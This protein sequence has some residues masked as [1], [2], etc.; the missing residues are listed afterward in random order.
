MTPPNANTKR[1]ELARILREKARAPVIAPLSSGQYRLWKIATLDPQNPVYNISLAYYL[2][3]QIDTDILHKSFELL[4]KRHASLRTHFAVHDDVPVQMVPPHVDV[5]FREVRLLDVSHDQLQASVDTLLHAEACRPFDLAVGPL[6]RFTLFALRTDTHVLSIT[7]HHMVGDRW[8]FGILIAELGEIYRCLQENR[9]VVL[10]PLSRTYVEFSTDQA[11]LLRSGI[12]QEQITFWDSELGEQPQPLVIPTGDVDPVAARSSGVRREFTIDAELTQQLNRFCAAQNVTLFSVVLASLSI[13]LHA[14]TGQQEM[15]VC[16]PLV[17]RYRAKTKDI[18]G[19][20]NNILPLRFYCS[21]SSTLEEHIA[22]L[23]EVARR[24][25]SNQDLPFEAI[26]NLDALR[27]VPL[28]RCMV[29]VQDVDGLQLILPN[30]TTEYRDIYSGASDFDISLFVESKTPLLSVLF[31]FRPSIVGPNIADQLVAHFQKILYQVASAPRQTIEQTMPSDVLHRTNSQFDTETTLLAPG[32]NPTTGRVELECRLLA[33][34]EDI[35]GVAPLDITDNFFRL[36]GHSFLAARLF[37]RIKHDLG[38]ELPL[39]MLFRSPTVIQLADEIITGSYRGAWSPLV[40]IHP[41]G[42]RPPLV[43]VH[44]GG[45]NVLTYQLLRKHLDDEQP[46]YGLQSLGLS[47]NSSMSRD[48]RAIARTYVDA[49]APLED[50]QPMYLGGHSFGA[51]VAYEMAQQLRQAGK[52][53]ALLVLFDTPGPGAELTLLSWLSHQRI[54]MSQL[55][56]SDRLS[57]IARGIGWRLNANPTIRKLSRGLFAGA[58]QDSKRASQR[59]VVLESALEAMKNYQYEP[60][61]GRALLLR[62]KSAAPRIHADR[63]GGWR[64]LLGDRL[65]VIEVLG[66]HMTMFS[67]EHAAALAATLNDAMK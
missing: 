37:A 52:N 19:Y 44:G 33:I 11:N 32:R 55:D 48:I 67:E 35:F 1:E 4:T 45:G 3:G 65:S 41:H 42:N 12:L 62:A 47:E 46:L 22:Q 28:S 31:D 8:S 25:F 5:D 38:I 18:V 63:W 54:N 39:A 17:G 7:A 36:G 13:A 56:W 64:D 51:I 29:S 24:A 49:L 66:D 20:F 21:P 53:V 9:D 26:A 6:W 10:P 61:E 58:L 16:V 14:M 15:L 60:Y 43:L 57:Y 59:L 40:P 23:R 50:G 2:S 27:N 30:M 34:W